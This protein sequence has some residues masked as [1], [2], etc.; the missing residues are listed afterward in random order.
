MEESIRDSLYR[1][2]REAFNRGRVHSI[3]INVFFFC[4]DVLRVSVFNCLVKVVIKFRDKKI[5]AAARLCARG[6]MIKQLSLL[7]FHFALNWKFSK[8]N[9]KIYRYTRLLLSK[10]SLAVQM[11]LAEYY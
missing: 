10:E 7:G 9:E 5:Y 11:K 2:L 4:S 6:L 1:H 8:R 3:R